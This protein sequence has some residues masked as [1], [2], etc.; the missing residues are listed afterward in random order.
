MRPREQQEHRRV[1]RA[2]PWRRLP[3]F[4]IEEVRWSHYGAD[5]EITAVKEG[6]SWLPQPQRIPHSARWRWHYNLELDCSI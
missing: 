4:E 5:I 1:A 6:L 2:V 3:T